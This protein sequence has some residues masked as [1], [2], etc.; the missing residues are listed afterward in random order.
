MAKARRKPDSTG[1]IG[2]PRMPFDE[3]AAA[4]LLRLTAT[5]TMSLKA[6]CAAN[7]LLPCETTIQNWRYD[8]PDFSR[9]Y[10]QAKMKQA[11]LMA[12]ECVEISDYMGNDTKIDKDGNEVP[13][14][15][16]IQ[17]SRLRVDTRKWI[18]CKLAPKLYGDKQVIEQHVINHEA[19]IKELE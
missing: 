14:H 3:L 8:Y 19:S 9:Q 11:E 12:E 4:E 13:N 16:Y 2:R 1:F 15:E 6:I 18:A 5:S 10:A 7:P 17:R